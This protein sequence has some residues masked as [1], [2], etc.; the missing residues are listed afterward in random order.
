MDLVR[1]MRSYLLEEK[2]KMQVYPNQV[3]LIYY[4]KIQDITD[5]KITVLVEFG[6]IVITGEH[7]VISRLMEDEV[8][9]TG[10]IKKIELS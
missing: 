7:L 3:D 2:F 6:N 4:Q 9:I 8:L 1:R 5:S 10:K